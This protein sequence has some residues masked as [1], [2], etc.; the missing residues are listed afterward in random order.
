M[1]K[2]ALVI[3][4]YATLEETSLTPMLFLFSTTLFVQKN[5]VFYNV[6]IDN[7]TGR[8]FFEPNKDSTNAVYPPSFFAIRQESKWI[9]DGITDCELKDQA[10]D[11]IHF[12]MD[13]EPVAE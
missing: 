9:F 11:D 1:C 7:L 4:D 8:F 2:S 6:F 12:Y 5:P 13:L 10:I 3:R